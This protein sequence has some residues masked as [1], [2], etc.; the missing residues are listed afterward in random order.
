MA[1]R[2]QQR[3][4]LAVADVAT[5]LGT[6]FEATAGK[7]GHAFFYALIESVSQVLD[8]HGGWVTEYVEPEGVLRALAFRLGDDWVTGYETPIGGTP[9]EQVVR[10]GGIIHHQDNVL[11]VYTEDADLHGIGAVSYLGVPLFDAEGG[12]LGNLAVIDTR[13]MP[14]DEGAEA[15]I[16]AFAAR[17]AAEIQRIRAEEEL[18]RREDKFARLIDAAMD[19]ILELDEGLMVTRANPAAERVLGTPFSGLVGRDFGGMLTPPSRERL[20][21]LMA[22][23]HQRP[24]GRRALWVPGGLEVLRGGNPFPAEATLASFE[25]SDRLY[26][27][28]I[29]RDVNDRTEAEKR[30][31]TLTA[32]AEYLR[33]EVRSRGHFDAIIGESEAMAAVLRDIAQVARTD[34]TVLIL[35]ETGTGK[36]L[37]ARAI[38]AASRRR[39]APLVTLNCA[40]V[41]AN[42]IESEF[43]GHVRGAFTGATDAREG[44]FALADGGTIFLDEVGELPV[45]LQA[46]LLRVLQEGEFEPVGSSATRRVDVRVVAATNRDLQAEAARGG[47]REDLYYRLAV[48]PIRMPPL[49]ERR[50]DIP[51]LARTFAERFS[52]ELGK[53]M[54]TA[55]PRCV[56]RLMAYPWPGNVRE[57]QNVMERAV[58]TARDACLNLDG[59]LPE[60]PHGD[61]RPSAAASPPEASQRN[62]AEAPILTAADLA[63]LERANM[64]R[65][66]ETCGWKVSGD[67]G[68]AARLGMK[69]STLASRMKALGLRRP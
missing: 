4:P 63:E 43:F 32:E 64:V 46:K 69:P 17:A 55:T 45:A 37:A 59:A 40:A 34:A 58:I 67:G 68:A 30:I 53:P 13:P 5:A 41:P 3:R 57:L 7:T 29:L 10:S 65:A 62:G 51:L 19:G 35:G 52:R 6:V 60:A 44:R 22:S 14:T 18:R 38:H 24:E 27:T 21:G 33:E 36:E 9:C 15:L 47:F 66:L 23:L 42:L 1:T 12:V 16:R 2:E 61:Q 49:R 25:A 11:E 39:D 50:E 54:P 26:Y 48:F 31:H 28:L 20:L 8:V 56:E